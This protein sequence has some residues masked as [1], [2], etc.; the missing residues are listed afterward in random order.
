MA[1]LIHDSL[2]CI[3]TNTLSL[4]PT[5]IRSALSLLGPLPPEAGECHSASLTQEPLAGWRQIQLV[6]G[7][8]GAR[9][10]VVVAL[11]DTAARPAM[12]SDLV[13][14][15][16]GQRQ[17]SLGARIDSAGLLHGTHWLADGDRHTPRP[18][19]DSEQDGLRAL[20]QALWDRCATT[21]AA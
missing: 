9:L 8:G 2:G 21:G 3:S 7:D 13:A 6:F 14:V 5:P 17:E 18:L 11:Y 12:I 19:T 4:A 10:R 20:A 15:D 1:R 16:G